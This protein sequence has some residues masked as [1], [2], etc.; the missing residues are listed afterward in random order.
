VPPSRPEQP[1]VIAHRGASA[2]APENT[3]E[4]YEL[5]VRC[6]ADC[7]ELDV[8]ADRAGRLLVSAE[9]PG[10]D[11][12]LTLE[13]VVAW[14]GDRA[15]RLFVELK[16]PHRYRARGLV[17]AVARLVDEERDAVLSFERPAV[18]EMH[19]LR[20][21]LPLVQHVTSRA[22]VV[23]AASYAWGVGFDD[24]RVTRAGIARA[25][26]LGLAPTVYTVNEPA[27]MAELLEWGAAGIYSDRPDVLRRVVDG[28]G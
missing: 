24:G 23:G 14:R 5:A 8:H 16:L 11:V 21:R 26:A 6:G 22:S 2:Y 17:E 7:I 15:V 25:R 1:L 27:R 18:V 19:R 10:A 28:S 3:L 13:D 20:P 9:P 4:A 12:D